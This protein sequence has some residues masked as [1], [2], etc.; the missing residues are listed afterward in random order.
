MPVYYWEE[1]PA[2]IKAMR[3]QFLPLLDCQT[4]YIFGF[5]LHSERNYNARIIRSLITRVHDAYGLPRQGFYFER[6]IWKSARVLTGRPADEIPLHES[7]QGLREFVRFRHAKLPRAKVVEGVLGIIQNEIEAMPGYV[8][9]DERSDRYERVQKHLLEAARGKRPYQ[10]FLL[11]KAEWEAK[12]TEACEKY[13][14]EPQDGRLKRTSPREAYEQNFDYRAGLIRLPAGCRYLLANHRRVEKV[15]SNGIRLILGGDPYY[16]RSQDTG[17]LIG[18]Q[19]LVWH[20][21]EERPESVT[22]TDLDRR[23]PIEVPRVDPVPAMTATAE[24][25]ATAKAGIEGH[26]AYAKTL[27]R[28]IQP[29]FQRN[30]FQPIL[31]DTATV[32]LG[33]QISAAREAVQGEEKRRQAVKR[34]IQTHARELGVATPKP[35]GNI[36]RKARGLEMLRQAREKTMQTE[37]QRHE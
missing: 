23:N 15:T 19:V 3:G 4:T 22:I 29:R 30:M 8:G 35:T 32:E 27:Y 31:V 37:D 21:L 10:S 24:Q 25:L 12:L 2:G 26:S 7:E 17:R 20:D 28:I 5:A 1:T 9:R 34:K 36:D 11:S 14:L 13:N 16:Y 33:Q 18:R 6:G